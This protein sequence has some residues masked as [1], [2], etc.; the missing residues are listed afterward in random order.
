MLVLHKIEQQFI[1]FKDG[2]KRKGLRLQCFEAYNQPTRQY[3]LPIEDSF[4][5][6]DVDSC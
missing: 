1:Y 4:L 5:V 6:H 2:L 3:K